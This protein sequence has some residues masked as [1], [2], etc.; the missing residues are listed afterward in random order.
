VDRVPVELVCVAAS[1]NPDI[2]R[3]STESLFSAL[4]GLRGPG[5][6]KACFLVAPTLN[7]IAGFAVAGIGRPSNMRES[8]HGQ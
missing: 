4:G 1:R 5:T 2:K 6:S 3:N 7:P 8:K